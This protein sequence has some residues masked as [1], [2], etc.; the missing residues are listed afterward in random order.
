MKIAYLGPAGTFTEEALWQLVAQSE[1]ENFGGLITCS[2]TDVEAVPMRNPGVAVAAVYTGEVDAACLAIENSVDGYVTPTYDALAAYPHDDGVQIYDEFYLPIRFAIM[3]RPGTTLE[4]ARTFA[5]HPVAHQQVQ[6]WLAHNASHLEFQ[7]ASSNGAAAAAVASGDV[8]VAAAPKRAAELYGLEI[9]ADDI[10]DFREARTRF[11]LI[12]PKGKAHPPT[13]ND[14]TSVMFVVPDE[15]GSLAS[16][17]AELSLRGVDMT[18]IESRPATRIMQDMPKSEDVSQYGPYRFHID[19]AGHI[20]DDAVAGA[21][22]AL[23]MRTRLLCFLGSW[24]AR[25]TTVSPQQSSRV[26]E[27]L[28]WVAHAQ[29]K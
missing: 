16:C 3:A 4:R 7:P 18:R 5:T 29:G 25:K 26:Q 21:L 9:L 23:Y 28:D 1:A 8:D 20:A 19:L 24:P 6:Q 27:A 15:P 17:L 2:A 22:Q 14:H 11:V 13:G 10:A 12:G